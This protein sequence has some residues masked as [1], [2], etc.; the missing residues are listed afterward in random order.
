MQLPEPRASFVLR[1]VIQFHQQEFRPGQRRPA[2][3]QHSLLIPLHI[4]LQQRNLRQVREQMIERGQADFHFRRHRPIAPNQSPHL[5]F[6]LKHRSPGGVARD[7]QLDG[8][9]CSAHRDIV[10]PDPRIAAKA[11]AQSRKRGRTR[12]YHR[13][14]LRRETVQHHGRPLA[15]IGSDI[16]H[17]PDLSGQTRRKQIQPRLLRFIDEPVAPKPFRRFQWAPQLPQLPPI[18]Q[19]LHHPVGQNKFQKFPDP[20][21]QR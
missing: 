20:H 5:L 17:M 13:E 2:T 10:Q 14:T 4:D 18:P 15:G 16:D 11:S 7:F 8:A 9:F 21:A 12:L 3:C 1:H 19:Y 6:R